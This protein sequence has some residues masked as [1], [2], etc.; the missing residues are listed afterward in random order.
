MDRLFRLLLPAM[1]ALLFAFSSPLAFGEVRPSDSETRIATLIEQLGAEDFAAR[2]K[3]QAELAQLGL[4]AFDALHAAQG[5]RDPEIALRARYLVRS[6][7]VRWFSESDSP[8]V[9]RILQ[10]YG[11]LQEG[12]KRNRME[13]LAALENRQGLIPLC[14]LSRFET[15]DALAKYAALKIMEL[16]EPEGQTAREQLAK[17]ISGIV[18]SSKRSAASWLR[19]YARTLIDPASTLAEWD[20]ASRVEHAQWSKMAERNSADRDGAEVVRDL[21]RYQVEL[22]KRLKRDDEAIEVIRRTFSLLDGTPEQVMDLVDWLMQ[23]QAW[24]VVLEVAEKFKTTFQDNPQLLYRL[25]EAYQNLGKSDEAEEAAQKALA[26]RPEDLDAHL[27]IGWTLE[28]ERGQT[29]WAEREYREVLKTAQAGSVH[30]LKGRFQLSELLHDQLQDQQAAE[31]LKPVCDLLAKDE[32]AKERVPRSAE[33]IVARMNYFYACH[34]RE[35]GDAAKE[36]LHLSAAVEAD[37]TDADVLIAMYRLIG[38]DDAWKTAIRQRIEKATADFKSE[39]EELRMAIEMAGNDQNLA[40]ANDELARACNQ[41]AWLVGNT[42]GDYDEAVKMSHKSLE[43]RPNYAGFLDTLGRSYY[44]KGDV[45]NAVKYQSQAAKLNTSS[46]QI[47][48]QL[49]FFVSEAKRMG[50]KM[51]DDVQ[52]TAQEALD[53]GKNSSPPER[54]RP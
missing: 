36:K 26:I 6:M 24:P 29:K 37:P 54:Q 50:M 2:E 14:R 34:Y 45:V 8:E 38:A 3:A 23:R 47:R 39:V 9:V 5:H 11:D 27:L 19:I 25:A 16:G 7:S 22:L 35:T 17:T 43:L 40:G 1:A 18:G 33:G 31:A 53:R 15:N 21:Y 49:E 52:R 13:K 41:Y 20:E 32:S 48:R 46:G 10:G 51:P 44:G 4:E 42:F 12:E 28:Q 30:D